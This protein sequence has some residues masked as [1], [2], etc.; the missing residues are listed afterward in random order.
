M[1]AGE[2][3][4]RDVVIVESSEPVKTA[5]DLM[6]THHVGDVVVVNKEDGSTRPIGI[7]T[8]RDIIVEI[9]A[10]DVDIDTVSV[11]DVMSYELV[12][13]PEETK[14]MDVIK[15]MRTSKARRMPVIDADGGLVGIL[16]ADDIV[17]LLSEQL[18][19]L[20][21]LI[22]NEINKEKRSRA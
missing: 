3:C 22:T 14:L 4:N 7:L 21:A 19:D 1:S 6:R 18:S 5:V 20:A 8:D 2:Y 16:T 12:A 11:G 9:L 15:T 17:E 10:E 13:V